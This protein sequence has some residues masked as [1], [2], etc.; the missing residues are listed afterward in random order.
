MITRKSQSQSRSCALLP[1]DATKGEGGEVDGERTAEGR[2]AEIIVAKTWGSGDEPVGQGSAAE[3][4]R[5]L[6]LSVLE[7]TWIDGP[8]PLAPVYLSCAFLLVAFCSS[9]LFLAASCSFH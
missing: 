8:L 9:G 1:G 7:F 6:L 2:G 5:K 4:R 3:G